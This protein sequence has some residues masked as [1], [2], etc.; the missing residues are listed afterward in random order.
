MYISLCIQQKALKFEKI[1]TLNSTSPK[2]LPEW[3]NIGQCV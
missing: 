1:I 2:L 3:E